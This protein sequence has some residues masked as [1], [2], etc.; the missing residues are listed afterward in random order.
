MAIAFLYW[1]HDFEE[2]N[3]M[4][5][6]VWAALLLFIDGWI[7]KIDECEFWGLASFDSAFSALNN[8]VELGDINFSSMSWIS[9]IPFTLLYLGRP[10]GDNTFSM[11]GGNRFFGCLV[12]H[13]FSLIAIG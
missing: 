11:I 2:E 6:L 1:R 9:S 13:S 8:V 3:W 5:F 7:L 4:M 12:W 10:T